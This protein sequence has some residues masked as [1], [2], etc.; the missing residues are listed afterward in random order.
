MRF[1]VTGLGADYQ[2]LREDGFFHASCYMAAPA[3]V[4]PLELQPAKPWIILHLVLPQP[5]WYSSQGTRWHKTSNEITL[6]LSAG[7]WKLIQTEEK[8]RNNSVRELSNPFL[9][10][11][12]FYP[13]HHK[14]HAPAA[15]GTLSKMGWLMDKFISH[16]KQ[17]VLINKI[18]AL[19]EF[20]TKIP[21]QS[22]DRE[23]AQVRFLSLCTAHRKQ[24]TVSQ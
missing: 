9:T 17:A 19:Q 10:L 11:P 15:P 20:F 12:K 7:M 14:L 24:A 4:T 5:C 1:Q 21:L 6:K 2:Y 23:A 3:S 22:G 16:S 13:V 18:P 8:G